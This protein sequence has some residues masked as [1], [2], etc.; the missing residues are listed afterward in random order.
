MAVLSDLKPKKVFE[1]F[2]LLSSVP[3]GSGNTKQI[4][5]LCVNFAKERGLAYVQDELNNVV[6]YKKASA[7]YENAET[8]IL[9]GHLDMVCAKDP[10]DPRDMSKEPIELVCDGEWVSAKGTSL[11][12][13]DCI[14]VAAAMAILDD[15]TLPH[16]A[17]EAVFTVDEETGMEGASGIDPS[18]IHGRR[19]INLD[20]E[21]EGVF[22]VGCAGGLRVNCSIPAGREPAHKGETAYRVTVSGLLGGH[23]GAEIHLERGNSHMLM[24]RILRAS[25][26]KYAIRLDRFEGGK[27]DNVIP[28]KTVA[29]VVIPEKQASDFEKLLNDYDTILKTELASSDPG[30]NVAFEKIALPENPVNS[31]ASQKILRAL[32]MLPCGMMNK[33]MDIEGLTQTSLSM[34]I[35]RL[36]ESSIDFCFF[37]RSSLESQKYYV[38]EKVRDI[39]SSVGG[40][41][42]S[43]TGYPGWAYRKDSPL[44]DIAAQA[45]RELTGKEAAIT[46]THGGL[47]CGLLIDKLPGLDIISFGPDLR[48][49]H[50][51]RERMNIGSV[52][53]MYEL[54][55]EILKKCR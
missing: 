14:A 54:V 9:Q 15:D 20:S 4:S 38:A 31:A 52:G 55:C 21:E 34:G 45:Y 41:A 22:T 27:F 48:D 8:V 3:H 17:L 42:V 36:G 5:D 43:N 25:A 16:P 37:I 13:D 6:I 1:F 7:G 46:A 26:R 51:V 33:S 47:E 29:D 11:G 30:V 40:T 19:M 50:S 35:I 18:L 49:I 12:G 2:E 32:V 44:R 10:D 53:R 28:S 23:S 39:I 24:G